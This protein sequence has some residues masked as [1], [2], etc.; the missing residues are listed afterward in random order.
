MRNKIYALFNLGKYEEVIQLTKQ[1]MEMQNGESEIDFKVSGIAHCILGKKKEA[2]EIWQSAQKSKYTDAAGG[3]ELQILLYFS[4]LKISDEVLKSY[5]KKAIKKLLKSKRA[6]NWPGPLGH[7]VLGN[8]T[9]EEILSYTSDLAI[10]R[11]RQLCQAYFVRGVK[12]LE[13]DNLTR[14]EENLQSSISF[15]PPTYLE[16]LFYL[17]KGELENRLTN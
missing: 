2:I 9:N 16:P 1:L 15:G 5:S 6:T 7:Y 12:E 8:L 13:K 11:E 3:V 4:S 17:A 14:Y 10:L